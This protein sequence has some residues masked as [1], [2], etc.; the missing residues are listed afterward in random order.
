ITRAVDV[1]NAVEMLNWGSISLGLLGL[2]DVRG[3]HPSE[4]VA[5]L[6]RAASVARERGELLVVALLEGWLGEAY[7]VFGDGEEA[8]HHGQASRERARKQSEQGTEAWAWRLLGECAAATGPP[9]AQEAES[10]Y[11]EALTRASALGM[12]PLVAHCHLGLG[13]LWHRMGK[14][15]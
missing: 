15:H 8:R 5:M 12:R 11:G 2:R 10:A 13:K 9:G 3:G 4:G 14:K 6:E 1:G 7:L